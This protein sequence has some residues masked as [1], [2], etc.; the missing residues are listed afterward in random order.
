[1]EKMSTFELMRS[2]Q[3]AMM[4]ALSVSA[5]SRSAALNDVGLGVSTKRK[6]LTARLFLSLFV[7]ALVVTLDSLSRAP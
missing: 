2:Q 1:M 3:I 4:P 6:P 7:I 5:S